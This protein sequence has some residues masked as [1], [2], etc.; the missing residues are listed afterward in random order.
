MKKLLSILATLVCLTITVQGQVMVNGNVQLEGALIHNGTKIVFEAASPSAT[1]DTAYT[2]NNGDFSLPLTAGLYNIIYSHAGYISYVLDGQFFSSATMLDPVQLY[3]PTEVN[4]YCTLEGA[5]EYHGT[6][7]IFQNLDNNLVDTVWTNIVGRFEAYLD[8]ANYFVL[9]SHEGFVPY[10]AEINIIEP[11]TLPSRELAGYPDGNI[12]S[13]LNSDSLSQ[14]GRIIAGNYLISG[15]VYLHGVDTFRVEP[16]V[17]LYFLDQASI[18]VDTVSTFLAEGTQSDSIYFLNYPGMAS[19]VM[20]DAL[21]NSLP[22]ISRD[23]QYCVFD[24]LGGSQQG[25]ISGSE[26]GNCTTIIQNSRFSGFN[27]TGV[28]IH[29][30]T[31]SIQNTYFV[32][33]NWETGL[34]TY[35]SSGEV[36]DCSF[37][38]S[39]DSAGAPIQFNNSTI[40]FIGNQIH[41]AGSGGYQNA[42]WASEGSYT[43][44][45][46]VIVHPNPHSVINISSATDTEFS[47]NILFGWQAGPEY[48]DGVGLSCYGPSIIRNNIFLSTN[49]PLHL[50]ETTGTTIQYNSFYDYNELTGGEPPPPGFGWIIDLTDS[51]DAYLNV[52]KNPQFM[53]PDIFD[54]HLSESSPCINAGDPNSELDPDGTVADIGVYPTIQGP[55]PVLSLSSSVLNFG[56]VEV[57]QVDTISMSVLNSGNLDLDLTVSPLIGSGFTMISLTSDTLLNPAE[58]IELSIAFHPTDQQEYSSNFSIESNDR[59]IDITCFG[60]GV[61]P[62]GTQPTS[63]FIAGGGDVGAN[64]DYFN[65][66][67]LPSLNHAYSVM[68]YGRYYG[69]TRIAYLNPIGFQDWNGDGVDD[70]IVDIDL[71]TTDTLRATIESL[72]DE[73]NDAFPNVLFFAGHGYSG[74]IDINGD[75]LDNLS[76]SVLDGWLDSTSLTDHTPL[77]ILFEA[78]FS[79]GFVP[80]LADSNRIIISACRDDQFADYMDGQCFSTR[81]WEEIWY[82]NSLADAFSI[83][84]DWS[85]VFLNA[86]EPQLDADGN[87][88]GN[89]ATDFAIADTIYLGGVYQHGAVLPEIVDA[90]EF[91]NTEDG[92][93]EVSIR[94]NRSMDNAWCVLYPVDYAGIPEVVELPRINLSRTDNFIYNG[95]FESIAPFSSDQDLEIIVYGVADLYNTIVPHIIPVFP[96]SASA[97]ESPVLPTETSLNACFPNPFNATI[98]LSFQI[99]EE[100][101]LGLNIYD[102]KGRRIKQVVYQDIL[103]GTYQQQWDGMNDYG[104]AVSSGIYI[105]QMVTEDHAFTRKVTL[106]K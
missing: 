20:L 91:L 19:A 72:I 11:T 6:R 82:G 58:S 34:G 2:G 28:W 90:P 64:W 54:F 30:T 78:C 71:I 14:E 103:P 46:N 22:S 88:I 37:I 74:E 50:Y 87:G 81:F 67:T 38:A 33:N 97:T 39:I 44:Q 99:A 18:R 76:I 51:T 92:K 57:N 10:Q 83:A 84:S 98:S 85:Q 73:N 12:I 25:L 24:G 32:T 100:T 29:R 61:P 42:I 80:T 13:H 96:G 93:I 70:E 35:S 75:A 86:Q 41:L 16:G 104:Q 17:R 105:V 79:G 63:L 66:N 68:S 45:R 65:S 40:D 89:E 94:F 77:V 53:N 60:N 3:A 69:D 9:F 7:I 95:T 23:F 52:F 15:N 102:I 48:S 55:H 43:F 4:G 1:S 8:R 26:G 21:D 31:F 62:S 59:D 27:S 101:Q 56:N 106:L 49:T 36:S 5:S 47:N